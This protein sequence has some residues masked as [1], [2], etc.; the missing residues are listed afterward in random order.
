MGTPV[1][2]DVNMESAKSVK[3]SAVIIS[4]KDMLPSNTDK[5]IYQ[6]D[7]ISTSPNTGFYYLS[8][9]VTPKDKNAA[10]VGLKSNTLKVKVTTK[11][12][13]TNVKV[14]VSE[15]DSPAILNPLVNIIYLF[16]I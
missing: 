15:K 14:A 2:V 5:S 16:L 13:L 8:I 4:K 10:I 7:L 1:N 9:V 3:Q 11:V 12:I 6:L